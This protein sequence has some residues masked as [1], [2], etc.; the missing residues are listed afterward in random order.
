MGCGG[1]VQHGGWKLLPVLVLVGPM[2]P[3]QEGQMP[4]MA[5]Q[6]GAEMVWVLLPVP[7]SGFRVQHGMGA[8]FSKLCGCC[9]QAWCVMVC[10]SCCLC[11]FQ[12]SG[13]QHGG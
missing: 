4:D 5:C 2:S 8:R 11:P 1:E 13:G 9:C 7:F 12:G 10:G 6:E 3:A